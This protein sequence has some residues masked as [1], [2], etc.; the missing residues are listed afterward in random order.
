M[1]SKG[2]RVNLKKF[3]IFIKVSEHREPILVVFLD[4]HL[5]VYFIAD[6]RLETMK[7]VL[8]GKLYK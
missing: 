4:T 3:F 2:E 8:L 7:C 5:R 1:E 6:Y